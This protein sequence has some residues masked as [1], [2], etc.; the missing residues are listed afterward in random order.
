MNLGSSKNIVERSSKDMPFSNTTRSLYALESFHLVLFM[1]I[2]L[3]ATFS[4][5]AF[6]ETVLS[7]NKHID[8][9][10]VW[11]KVDSPIIIRGSLRIGKNATLEIKS[12]TN[13]IVSGTFK[14][15][16]GATLKLEPGTIIK[17]VGGSYYTKINVYGRLVANGTESNPIIFTS[18]NYSDNK[19]PVG[20]EREQKSS[21]PGDWLGINFLTGSS[22]RLDHV[23]IQYAGKMKASNTRA[24]VNVYSGDV[25]IKNSTMSMG[26]GSAV[27]LNGIAC[28]AILENNKYLGN[29]W[30]AIILHGCQINQ[31]TVLDPAP[32][33]ISRSNITV[34]DGVTLRLLPGTVIKFY[35]GRK[36][37]G[38]RVDGRLVAD[39]SPDAPV[40]FTSLKDDSVRGD[41]NLDGSE[42]NPE[43]GDWTAVYFSGKSSGNWLNN[44]ELRYAGHSTSPQDRNKPIRTDTKKLIVSNLRVVQPKGKN[45]GNSLY[46]YRLRY[47]SPI[48]INSNLLRYEDQVKKVGGVSCKAPPHPSLGLDSP[49]CGQ[50]WDYDSFLRVANPMLIQ[51]WQITEL[52]RR[53]E[54]TDHEMTERL[55]NIASSLYS[56]FGPSVFKGDLSGDALAH[57]LTSGIFELPKVFVLYTADSKRPTAVKFAQGFAV[58]LLTAGQKKADLAFTGNVDPRAM[59]VEKTAHLANHL[60]SLKTVDDVIE[61]FYG[62]SIAQEYL[63]RLL[64]NGGDYAKLADSMNLPINVPNKTMIKAIAKDLQIESK[65]WDKKYSYKNIT[66]IIKNYNYE[67]IG[68]VSATCAIGK[69]NTEGHVSEI[70]NKQVNEK[71]GDVKDNTNDPKKIIDQYIQGKEG[72]VFYSEFS[73]E[74]D[75]GWLKGQCVAWAEELFN[76]VSSRPISGPYGSAQG[77]PTRANKQ[78]FSVVTQEDKPAV[79]SLIV[80]TYKEY[81]HVGVVTDVAENEIAVSEGN[82]GEVTEKSAEKWGITKKK[83][84]DEFVTEKYG[85]FTKIK[86]PLTKLDR[87]DY[88]F[89]AY[90]YPKF[91]Q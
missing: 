24:S 55:I 54:I 56:V 49:S 48:V 4:P 13:V 65:R 3:C 78:G 20:F 2:L 6:S 68:L 42:T 52:R 67:W 11:S 17:A 37:S 40:I 36:A 87:D 27:I 8:R 25:V 23:I 31:D 75:P 5:K 28:S 33:Y 91:T 7:S 14:I 38:I 66:K 50:I 26:D 85:I 10:T 16:K 29:R 51:Q 90:I 22:G 79:G 63:L 62:I 81:G 69:C 41:T 59:L 88:K 70:E 73:K 12:G 34:K 84:I 45:P 18:I 1:C 35:A 44:M 89:F 60:N 43:M 74:P 9:D 46:K 19:G 83:A 30:D 32:T 39:G 77:I 80:W 47:T 21:A 82:W 57:S 72:N 58:A 76:E 15:E 64:K 71:A 86:L 53:R 61:D